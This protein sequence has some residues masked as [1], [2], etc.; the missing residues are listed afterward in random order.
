ML[1]FS[2]PENFLGLL[3]HRPQSCV[4]IVTY[5]T[6]CTFHKH[7]S[8]NF[9]RQSADMLL[10][11][12]KGCLCSLP[13]DVY[14]CFLKITWTFLFGW[15]PVYTD[16][17]QWLAVMSIGLLLNNRLEIVLLHGED[18]RKNGIY[19]FML[20]TYIFFWPRLICSSLLIKARSECLIISETLLKTLLGATCMPPYIE[21]FLVMHIKKL[22]YFKM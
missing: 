14:K 3:R 9:F 17:N 21:S 16:K 2:G 20:V 15:A 5:K 19:S 11:S 10:T 7:T 6:T 1:W 12:I 18:L 8:L 22:P 4:L 13:K